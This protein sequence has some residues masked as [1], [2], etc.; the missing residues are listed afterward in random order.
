M[1]IKKIPEY[2]TKDKKEKILSFLSVFM[3]NDFF[4]WGEAIK[5]NDVYLK[6]RIVS[7]IALFGLR[8]ILAYNNKLFP[9]QKWLIEAVKTLED[10]PEGIIQKT[11]DFLLSQ[12]ESTKEILVES[13]LNFTDWD[14]PDIEAILMMWNC[15]G[16]R[17]GH[18]SL[19]G[20][21]VIEINYI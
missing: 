3:I 6:T 19:N 2:P 8:L 17:N 15:G 5:R 13:I 11:N 9:C 7:D 16:G 18:I 20:N 21:N 12:N 14:M 1:F 10:K 4:F